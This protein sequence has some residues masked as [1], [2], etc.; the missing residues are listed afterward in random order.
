MKGMSCFSNRVFI[1]ASLR[2]QN[3]SIK[4]L[5][6]VMP[7][8]CLQQ[9]PTTKAW[10]HGSRASHRRL[11]LSEELKKVVMASSTKN[12]EQSVWT[13]FGTAL[14]HSSQ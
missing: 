6:L 13:N 1:E 10:P 5:L 4:T 7:K 8:S 14:T 11:R 12:P 3:A 2:L 9:N